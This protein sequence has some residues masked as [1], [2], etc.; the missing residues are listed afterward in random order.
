MIRP[1][2]CAAVLNNDKILMVCH[3]T[4]SRTYWTFPGGAVEAGE[5]MEQA[6]V[7]EVKEETGLNVKA[8]R[9]IFEEKYEAGVSYCYLAELIDENT[10]VNLDFLPEDE[11][12]FGTM[13]HSASWHYI[14]D[15]KEDN[16]VSK[17]IS[18]LG[19]NYD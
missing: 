18:I 2:A 12:V 10:V 19:L 1:R 14:K 16:Q 11:S 6:A 8:V 5:T 17:V 15:K 3:Q 13:L 7:R 9:L 4:P